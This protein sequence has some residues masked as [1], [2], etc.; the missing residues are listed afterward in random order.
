MTCS[1]RAL[2]KWGT[3]E[4]FDQDLILKCN[5]FRSKWCFWSWLKH[6]MSASKTSFFSRTSQLALLS[7]PPIF[8]FARSVHG[9]RQ[10]IAA[11]GRGGGP[12]LGNWMTPSTAGKPP[13]P[14][15]RTLKHRWL[16]GDN[17][18][19]PPFKSGKILWVFGRQ[20][21]ASWGALGFGGATRRPGRNRKI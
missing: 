21:N 19:T 1:M 4:H 15:S 8:L 7:L 9:E 2:T 3:S 11:S 10:D 17:L 12:T 18:V 16:F 20:Q 5:Q 6:R 13:I 14:P